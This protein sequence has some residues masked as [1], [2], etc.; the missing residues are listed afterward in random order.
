[1]TSQ[2]R[3]MLR[4]PDKLTSNCKIEIQSVQECQSF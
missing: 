1:M 4:A 3:L 2:N